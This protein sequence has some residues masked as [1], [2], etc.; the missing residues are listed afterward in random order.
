MGR[1][2]GSGF[3]LVELVLV[4]TLLGIMSL[5]AIPAILNTGGPTTDGAA[6]KLVSD[7]SYAR[8]LAQNRNGIYGISFEPVND[9]YTVYVYDPTTNTTTP[10]TDPL[11]RMPMTVD[12]QVL[13]GLRGVDIQ[14]PNFQGGTEARF[15]PQGR[16]ADA[17]GVLLT[18]A[19]SV[20]LS[21]GGVSRTVSV[22]P[23]TGEVS[24]Q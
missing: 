18:A 17:N 14:N 5:A 1:L 3:T 23:N 6:R 2:R 16:P 24:Y 4:L 15:D 11:T 8:R 12:F 9:R 22:Q 19:G 13:P 20:V 10:I 7:L 21:D